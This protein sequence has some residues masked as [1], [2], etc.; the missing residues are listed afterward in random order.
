[1]SISFYTI[2]AYLL[3]MAALVG[4]NAVILVWLERKV[5][6]HMQFRYG[7]MEVGPHGLLQTLADGIK[8]VSKQFVIPKGGGQGPVLLPQGSALGA[9]IFRRHGGPLPFSRTACKVVGT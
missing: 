6:G 9:P 8:L 1:M 2:G 4:L 7:P 5:A 3:G